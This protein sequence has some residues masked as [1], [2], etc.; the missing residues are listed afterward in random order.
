M[1]CDYPSV[2]DRR[3]RRKCEMEMRSVGSVLSRPREWLV[4]GESSALDCLSVVP[5]LPR[6]RP[7]PAQ[8]GAPSRPSSLGP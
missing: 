2:L 8:A 3:A 5:F 7:T 4:V 6:P 1:S